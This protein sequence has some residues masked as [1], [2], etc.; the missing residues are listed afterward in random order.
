MSSNKLPIFLTG[1]TGYIGGSVLQRLLAHPNANNFEI[2]ALVRSAKKAKI[3]ESKSG[4]KTVLGSLQDSEKLT[5]LVASAHVTINTAECDDVAV[6]SA[7]LRGL[8]QRREKIGDAPHFIHTSGTGEFID[9]ARGE[10]VSEKVYSDVDISAIEAL[11]PSAPHRPVD[12]LVVAADTEGGYART[13]I[14]MP[15]VVYG[16]ATGPLVDAGVTNPHT[17]IVPIFVR[18]ALRRGSVGVLDKGASRWGNVHIDDLADLYIRLLDA[19]LEDPEKVSH[20]REGYFF[21]DNGELSMREV[22]PSI[23]DSLF[24]LGRVSTRELVPYAPGEAGQYLVNEVLAGFLFTHSRTKGERAR[25]ELGWAPKHTA[26]DFLDGLRGEVEVLVGK[27]D[28]KAST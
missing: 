21:A 13:H 14:V 7:I 15:S 3:L 28:A 4:V 12:L 17:I 23:A 24:A 25:R 10:F 6:I 9:D 11:P 5:Q 8:K 19:I 18:G 26:Q 22:L 1:A 27:E 16:V 20:G 2:T